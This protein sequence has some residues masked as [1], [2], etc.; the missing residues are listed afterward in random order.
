[1]FGRTPRAVATPKPSDARDAESVALLARID[2]LDARLARID[3]LEARLARIDEVE[4]RIARLEERKLSYYANRW[5]VID[6]LAD[7]LVGAELPGDYCE[8]GVLEGKTFSYMT[9]YANLFPAMRFV[10]FDSFEGLPQL[11]EV[12]RAGAYSSGFFAGQFA[13]DV[14]RFVRNVAASGAPMDRVVTVP[15]WFD[16]TL[17]PDRASAHNVNSVAAAWIDCDLYASTVPVLDFLST[18]LSVGSVLLF[19]DWRCFRNMPDRGQQLACREWLERNPNIRLH[20]FLD[21]GFHGMSFTV[22]A[23]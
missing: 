11:G 1:M 22:G 6:K 18:R 4:A 2:E 20:E 19:D 3:A 7:Y 10:A 17:R 15:G 12:D 9:R 23:C 21:F 13:C 16:Q 14:D 8:F 5:D